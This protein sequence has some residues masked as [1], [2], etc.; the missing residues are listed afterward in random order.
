M[1]LYDSIG[2]GYSDLRRAD[3]RIA[4]SIYSALGDARRVVNVGAGAG[5][6]EPRDREVIAVELSQTMIRQRPPGAAAVVQ[7]SA[8]DL[9]FRDDCFEAAMALLTI[10]H[11]PDAERGLRE[12]QRISRRRVLLLTYDPNRRFWLHEYFPQIAEIDLQI[13]PRMEQLTR[14]LGRIEVCEVAIPHDC[15]DGF[16]GAY[17][18]R[19]A[20]YL[21][22]RTRA[23]ISTFARIDAS[24]GLQ[25]L[26]DD[27]ASGRWQEGHG[28]LLEQESL[29]VGYRLV[30]ASL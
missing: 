2:N 21:D 25:R 27:L 9:P 17:W 14:V 8:T 1:A 11:W 16:L 26:R 13:M 6:Y 18:R 7:A 23:A 4:A 12:M 29:D 30:V 3:A 10:H 28:Y 5:S 24:A 15:S 22:E 19:P 20:A